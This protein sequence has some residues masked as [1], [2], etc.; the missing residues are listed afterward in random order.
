VAAFAYG[1]RVPVVDTNVRRVVARAVAGAAEPGPPSTARDLAAVSAL[2]PDV[3]APRFSVAL[4][5]LGALV[6][7][8]RSPRC[9]VCPLRSVCAWRGAG[10]PPYEGPARRAQSFAGTDRQVR[11]LLMAVLRASSDPVPAARLDAVWPDPVQRAR[12]LDGLVADGLVDPVAEGMYALPGV[13][14]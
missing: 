2:L 14:G 1:Q 13:R 6:C 4:M 12:A 5:E 10:C 8:A 11:G 7:T 3:D 9:P